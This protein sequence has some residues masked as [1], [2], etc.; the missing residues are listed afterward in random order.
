[1]PE[2]LMPVLGPDMKTGLLVEWLVGPGDVV[3]RGQP[4]AVVE[5]SK[6]AIDVEILSDGVVDQLLVPA[7]TNVPVGEPIAL[8]REL[9]ADARG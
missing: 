8:V 4:V 3:R 1:M 6:G 9:G 2:F 7:G 5:T